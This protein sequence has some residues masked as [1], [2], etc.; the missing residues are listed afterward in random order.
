MTMCPCRSAT[1]RA[2]S[3]YSSAYLKG[4][5]IQKPF[6]N[7]SIQHD[8][9]DPSCQEFPQDIKDG[10]LRA[11]IYGSTLWVTTIKSLLLRKPQILWYISYFT[12]NLQKANIVLTFFSKLYLMDSL[13]ST[14]RGVHGVGKCRVKFLSVWK[15]LYSRHIR[16][17]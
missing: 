6:M 7:P 11:D 1:L 15:A 13:R 4:P 8:E 14:R 3:S 17:N 9:H 10:I 12:S 16:M 5:L 2:R